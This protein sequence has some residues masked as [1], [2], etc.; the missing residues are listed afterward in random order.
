MI[1]KVYRQMDEI[2]IHAKKKCRELLTSALDF[3]PQIQYWYDSIHAYLV[4]LRLKEAGSK[5][6]N[7]VNVHR[8]VGR[9]QIEDSRGLTEDK[10]KESLCPCNIIMTEL[11]KQVKGLRKVHIRDCLIDAQSKQ[12]QERANGSRQKIDRKHNVRMWYLIQRTVKQPRNLA[13]IKA[14]KIVDGKTETY[15]EQAEVKATIQKECQ[16][17]FTLAHRAPIMKHL[18]AN[19]LKCL[20]DEDIAKAIVEV[21]YKIPTDFDE[22]SRLDIEETRKLGMKIR[23]KEGKDIIITPQDFIKFWKQVGKFTTSSPSGLRYSHHKVSVRSEL[24]TNIHAQQLTIIARSGVY[25]GRWSVTFQALLEKIAG[26]CLVEKLRYIQL[27]K[28]DFSFLWKF[29]F[30]R[31]ALD[32]LTEN[33]YLPEEHF[34]KKGS[35]TEDNKFD[36]TL[37]KDL[38]R[39]SRYPMAVVSVNAAQCYN[40]VNQVIVSLVWLALIRHVGPIAVIL[41][42]LQSMRVF[43]RTIF[44]NSMSFLDL[45]D[46]R[47]GLGQGSRDAPA[48]W[49]Q[50][51]SIIGMI[52][53]SLYYGAKIINP[54]TISI[55]HTV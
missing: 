23:N 53:R 37:T 43:Q 21:T 32:T 22:A 15:T 52:L 12:Q 1:I 9:C 48:S 27:Y 54:V 5:R 10:I 33:G 38:S 6:G 36:K 20:L 51:S 26:V 29:I 4:L 30:G 50:I 19:K 28:A 13:V 2:R 18:L 40:R 7:P 3:S 41:S 31:E 34:S 55:I 25:P 42:Y 14:Q 17:R 47:M 49:V 39:Q 46:Y 35:T 11:R 8:F 45:G 16:I 24:S 44:G